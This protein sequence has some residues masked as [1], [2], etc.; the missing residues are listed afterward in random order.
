MAPTKNAANESLNSAKGR[1]RKH[2]STKVDNIDE[3]RYEVE[4]IVSHK[5]SKGRVSRYLVKWKDYSSETNTWEPI[6]NLRDCLESV[7]DYFHNL[8]YPNMDKNHYKSKKIA[9]RKFL[10]EDIEF[11]LAN[12]A[13]IYFTDEG[14]TIPPVNEEDLENLLTCLAQIP[15]IG[16]DPK[17][18]NELKNSLIFKELL[19]R[20]TE[21][22]NQ[23]KQWEMDIQA[24]CT[25]AA[26]IKIVNSVDL[27]GPPLHFFYIN[28]Y[29]PGPDV[30]IPL[31]PPLG[32]ECITCPKKKCCISQF[33]KTTYHE[34]LLKVPRGTPIYECNKSCRC[35][36]DCPNRVLQRGRTVPVAIFRTKNGCGWGL[37]SMSTIKK[38]Q[39]VVE[40]VGEVITNRE[41]ER[42]GQN[43]DKQG[44]TYLFDLDFNE[45][46]GFPYSVDA[47]VYGNVSHFINHSCQPNLEVFAV[48]VDCLDPN[49]PRLGLFASKHIK[50]NEEL[51]FD[52]LCQP[53]KNIHSINENFKMKKEENFCKCGAPNCRKYLFF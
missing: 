24:T 34:G 38:G 18:I 15:P 47:A 35:G 21:Q 52:Y 46:D 37:R 49:I 31:E 4:Q 20:R 9:L 12:F 42:R 29:I 33:G 39:F 13:R 40:Y 19:R 14:H 51:T 23:L 7:A 36:L 22:L 17:L 43:Y 27:E 1:K 26:T 8:L 11:D 2:S 3:E 53:T 50:E 41:A 10:S 45:K 16:H 6:T 25:D 28:S 44:C 48:W 5:I 32:C 30:V